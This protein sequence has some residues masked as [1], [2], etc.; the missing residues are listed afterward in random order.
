MK[1]MGPTRGQPTH[2]ASI[3][4]IHLQVIII[5]IISRLRKHSKQWWNNEKMFHWRID[6]FY[7]V[8]SC[9]SEYYQ[10]LTCTYSTKSLF[11]QLRLSWFE[12]TQRE[13]KLTKSWFWFSWSVM[14]YGW[15]WS[16][17]RKAFEER[18]FHFVFLKWNM[19]KKN[20]INL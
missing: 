14:E 20:V 15:M 8:F 11:I 13:T 12:E 2:K 18:N 16:K 3:W 10:S 19:I 1:A 5:L 9:L 6:I 17:N 4:N 7:F